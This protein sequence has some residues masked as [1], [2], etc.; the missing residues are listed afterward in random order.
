MVHDVGLANNDNRGWATVT[1][2]D[3]LRSHKDKTTSV[4]LD[5]L[6][7][8]SEASEDAQGNVSLSDRLHGVSLVFND[9]VHVVLE[10]VGRNFHERHGPVGFFSAVM[11]G[12]GVV[13]LLADFDV[14][15]GRHFVQRS[16]N[17][18]VEVSFNDVEFEKTHF[19]EVKDI[20]NKKG[21]CIKFIILT[22]I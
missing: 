12:L 10:H 19:D 11:A 16:S 18:V 5:H 17:F 6:F 8:G 4:E 1:H 14:D 7:L 2:T 13:D 21:M 9:D 22:K 3:K 15:E 20:F